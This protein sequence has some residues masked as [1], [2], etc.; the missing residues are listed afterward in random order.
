MMTTLLTDAF[1]FYKIESF[2]IG[3]L[4][5][6]WI[7]F[8]SNF[9]ENFKLYVISFKIIKKWKLIRLKVSLIKY[10]KLAIKV[11]FQSLTSF[12]NLK[13]YPSM[14]DLV[15]GVNLKNFISNIWTNFKYFQKKLWDEFKT[16]LLNSLLLDRASL[17]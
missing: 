7:N 5:Y 6:H 9:S 4:N 2:V 17:I 10:W 14:N 8:K 12:G 3:M 11:N 13:P 16:W 1:V 15:N